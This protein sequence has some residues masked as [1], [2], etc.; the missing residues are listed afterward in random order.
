[1]IREFSEILLK[2]NASI[3]EAM[4]LLDKTAEK[5]LFIIDDDN[6]LIG[7]LSDGDIRRWILKDGSLS[8]SVGEVCFKGTYFLRDGYNIEEVRREMLNRRIIF[9]PIVD[10]AHKITLILSWD[11]IFEGKVQRKLI[12][13]LNLPVVIMAGGK[14]TRLDPFTKVLPKPLIPI[15]DKTILEIIIDKFVE[16]GVKEFTLSLNYK[17]KIIKSY[18]EEISPEYNLDYLLENEPLGTAGAIKLY[19]PTKYENFI[20]TNCDIIIE[21]DYSDLLDYHLS[22]GYDITVVASMKHIKIPYGVCKLT[23]DGSLDV[24]EEKPEFDYLVS[25]G[26]YI[27]KSDIIQEIPDN[28]T[29]HMTDLI[30]K[31]R[32]ENRRVGIYPISENA[33]ID[34]GEWVEYKKA[35]GRLTI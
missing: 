33:W 31:I 15:G 23:V 22:G 24:I 25:T 13:P 34:T 16:Y 14:G 9:V 27:L 12:Q 32:Q 3:K 4:K 2:K 8:E 10:E 18:F 29:F 6:K 19:D 5:I 30:E 21:A 1:M 11:T 28:K 35:V 20:V 26:M 17:A 7:S